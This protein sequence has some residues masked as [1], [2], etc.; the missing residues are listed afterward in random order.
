MNY[1]KQY[2]LQEDVF[3]ENKNNVLECESCNL[4][5]MFCNTYRS[6]VTLSLLLEIIVSKIK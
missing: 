2:P 3:V 5:Q 6:L 4:L 1:L